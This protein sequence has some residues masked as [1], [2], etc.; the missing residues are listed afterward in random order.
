MET[1]SIPVFFVYQPPGG[2]GLLS[3]YSGHG[4]P[5]FFV[6]DLALLLDVRGID[7]GS[8]HDDFICDIAPAVAGV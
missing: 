6:F 5:L 7:L 2:G 4:R 8:C 1:L 3:R